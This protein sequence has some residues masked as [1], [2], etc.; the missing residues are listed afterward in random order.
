MTPPARLQAAIDLLGDLGQSGAP[1]DKIVAE[2]FRAHRYIGA[3]DRRAIADLVYLVLRRR[4]SLDWWLARFAQNAEPARGRVIAALVL[5]DHW[6]TARIGSAFDGE[7]RHPARLAPEETAFVLGLA[8]RQGIDHPEQPPWVRYELP[9]WLY[10]KLKDAFGARLESELTALMR[11]AS[12][13]LR[14]NGLKGTRE[15]GRAALAAEGFEVVPTPL[16]PVG[17]RLARRIAIGAT[18]AFREGLVEVQDEGSQL[19]ALLLGAEPGMRVCDFCAGAGGKTLALAAAMQNRGQIYALDVS[20][21]RLKREKVRVVRAGVQN[22]ARKLLT[23]HRDPWVKRHK[24][25]FDRVLVD[26]PCS[27]S[28]TWRRNPDAKWR[29]TPA[30][31]AEL[32]VLQHDILASAARL[33]RPG[34]RLLYVT[35]SLL[36]EENEAQAA[37]FLNEHSDFRASSIAEAWER[38]VGAQAAGGVPPGETLMLTPAGHGTDGF[39]MAMFERS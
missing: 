8:G 10:A 6:D 31:L 7:S 18:K 28:G 5:F 16:S 34:G 30:D 39:F 32:A 13:D 19:A 3:K 9:E 29:L 27:G 15:E 35:C 1:A 37:A 4:A 23:G 2:Y 36:P 11:E 21:A 20:E 17:L 26:A 22:V 38:I 25:S 24:A 12:F 33:L 14:V